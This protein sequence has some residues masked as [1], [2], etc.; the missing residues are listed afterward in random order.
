MTILFDDLNARALVADMTPGLKGALEGQKPLTLYLG[1][2]P[3]SDSL[4]LGSLVGILM[5]ERF[6]LKGHRS[7]ALVGGAT[8]MIGDPSGRSKER[9][10]LTPDILQ[11]NFEAIKTQIQNLT[12]IPAEDFL[13]N[14]SWWNQMGALDFLRDVGKHATINQ[15]TAKESVR[16]RMEGTEGI[17]YTE[18]SYML[19]QAYDFYW[20]HKEKDCVLQVGGSDQWGNITAGTD[21]IRRMSGSEAHGLT[22]PLLEKSDGQKFG[23]TADETIWLSPEKTSAF[24]FY[25]YLYNLEDQAATQLLFWLTF[26]PVDELK[27]LTQSHLKKPEARKAQEHLAS[28]VTSY[29][30]GPQSAQQAADASKAVFSEA[31]PAAKDLKA[32]SQSMPHT[33]VSASS[34]K[35]PEALVGLLVASQ[36][37]SSKGDARRQLKQGGIS[38]N[39][40]KV[41]SPDMDGVEPIDGSYFLLGK[42]KRQRHLVILK[43]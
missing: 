7:L 31:M 3:T 43:D 25:Q 6:R 40:S 30:H 21:L 13:D 27:E 29:V 19:L 35:E 42:G 4:H 22:W 24:D 10:L 17:S 37:C 16:S 26:D 2:D 5:L 32:L 9:N 34:L 39:G 20:L 12:E 41:S 15:M 28:Q 8:G 33:Q 11:H 36:L 18:F 14:R 38:I 1:I 23:K